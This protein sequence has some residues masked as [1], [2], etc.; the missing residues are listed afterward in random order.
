M[1]ITSSAFGL[2]QSKCFFVILLH[3]SYFKGLSQKSKSVRSR[4]FKHCSE[5]TLTEASIES[6]VLLTTL[7]VFVYRLQN[8]ALL[9]ELETVLFQKLQQFPGGNFASVILNF[10]CT[11]RKE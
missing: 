2:T 7:M 10:I 1:R 3:H 4:I 6:S 8:S 9:C 5:L 11:A